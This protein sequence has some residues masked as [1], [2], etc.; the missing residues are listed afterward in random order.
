MKIQLYVR[1]P[2]WPATVCPT[3]DVTYTSE[4]DAR[5]AA[6]LMIVNGMLYPTETIL[7]IVQAQNQNGYSVIAEITQDA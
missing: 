7:L 3:D 5:S 4:A 1:N 2:R 6:N